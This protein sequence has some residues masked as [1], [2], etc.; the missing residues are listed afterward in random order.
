M[1]GAFIPDELASV[2][3]TDHSSQL[4]VLAPRHA[5]RHLG[6]EDLGS[7]AVGGGDPRCVDTK[8]GR[9]S[10]AVSEAAD[11]GAEVDARRE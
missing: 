8:G 1:P 10:P 2:S 7:F 4:V 6:A 11:D 5:L 9:S 3:T